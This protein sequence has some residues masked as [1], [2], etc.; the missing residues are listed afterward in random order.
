MGTIIRDEQMRKLLGQLFIVG[1]DGLTATDEIKRLI[2]APYYVGNIV[3]FQRNISTPEQLIALVNELQQ[4]ASDAG[5]QR[6]LFISVDQ[7]NGLVTRIIPPVAARL[8]G[9]MALGATRSVD[10]ILQVSRATGELLNSFGINMNYAPCCDVNSEPSN[11]IIGV[12]S[13]GDDGA[14]VAQ[15]SAAFAQGQREKNVVPCAKHFP[16]HGDTTEDSHLALPVIS[17]DREALEAC[18]LIPFRRAAAEQIEAVMMAHI[19]VPS[20]DDSGLPSSLSKKIVKLLRRSL[21]Y[22]GLIV[23]DCLEMDAVRAQYGTAK[24]AVMSLEAGVDCAMICHTYDVQVNAINEVF[25]AC[26]NGQI[27]MDQIQ[28]S[29]ERVTDLKSRFLTWEEALKQ[30][31]PSTIDKL[32]IAHETLAKEVYKRSVTVVRDDNKVLPLSKEASVVYAYPSLQN[33][34]GAATSGDESDEISCTP[35]GFAEILKS[36]AGQLIALPF[37]ET[38]E[39]DDAL[40]TEITC[41]DVVILATFNANRTPWQREMGAALP[42]LAKTLI[43]VATCDPY[44]FLD[45]PEIKTCISMYEPTEEAFIAAVDVIF[46]ACEP[47]GILPV[48]KSPKQRPIVQFDKDRDMSQVIELWHRVLPQYAVPGDVLA[49]LLNR[50]NSAHFVV[51]ENDELLGFVATFLNDGSS[52]FISA[53]LVNPT[54]QS[55]GIGSSLISYARKYLR[56]ERKSTSI[57]V[58][59]SSPRFWPGVP[60][61]IQKSAYSFFAHRGFCAPPGPSSRDYYVNLLDYVAPEG[62]LEHSAAAGVTFRPWSEEQYE[63]CMAKQKEL[64]GDNAIW[65]EA[66]EQLAREGQYSQA[67]VAVDSSG[68][69]VGWT[70]MLNPRVGLFNDLAFPLLLGE[71][72]GQIACVGVDAAARKKGVGLALVVSAALDLK[73]RGLQ[74]AFIDWVT[75]VNWYEKAGFEV[76]REYQPM[77]LEEIPSS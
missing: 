2:C 54:Y 11:P 73:K 70:L 67:M 26:R 47:Q 12:R 31:S 7:E 17:R 30:R 42:Q 43:S 59:S 18:E 25:Q 29:V 48:L 50:S 55:R 9:A 37:T 13:A 10:D 21:Q 75:L 60:L 3:L 35:P 5:H 71:K 64:F 53:L 72:T 62:V 33:A 20:I 49:N 66:Y 38:F 14:S 41:A 56:N 1:F 4:T 27:P 57:T 65:V 52:S 23:T 16:G 36:R 24:G 34:H 6:P 32:N 69:Q 22:N 51:R 39:I 68:K 40:R 74:H 45:C 19:V 46:G 61:D 15:F 63:E 58:G 76:W 28:R 44:D 77:T 8:P